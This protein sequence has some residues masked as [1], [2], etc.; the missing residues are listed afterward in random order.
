MAAQLNLEKSSSEPAK[1]D[2]NNIHSE[3]HVSFNPFALLRLSR[4]GS[5]PG[6]KPGTITSKPSN[7]DD[8][9]TEGKFQV[10]VLV[11][12]PSA[13]DSKPKTNEDGAEIPDIVIGVAHMPYR[14]D[15]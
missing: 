9:Q 12:M 5:S 4:R 8:S 1:G 14:T 6:S 11:V 10:S 15:N 13:P 2:S 3:A 7:L